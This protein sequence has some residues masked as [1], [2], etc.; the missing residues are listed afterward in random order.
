MANHKVTVIKVCPTCHL[1]FQVGGRNRPP[2]DQIFCRDACFKASRIADPNKAR[3]WVKNNREKILAYRKKFENQ[4]NSEG[5]KCQECGKDLLLRQKRFCSR[6]CFNDGFSGIKNPQ[7]K[8]GKL[9]RDGYIRI[10]ERKSGRYILEHRLI[11]EKYLGRPLE[12]WEEIHHKNGNRMDNRIENLQ[13][14]SRKHGTGCVFVC[15]DCGSHNI[16]AEDL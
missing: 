13:L 1:E 3:Q 16:K 2:K 4:P 10:R 5:R 11:M 15:L 7:W 9:N 6:Q 12:K 14:R 8:G